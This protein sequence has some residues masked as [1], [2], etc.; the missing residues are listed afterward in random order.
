M[1]AAESD[2]GRREKIRVQGDPKR[3]LLRDLLELLGIGLAHH[4]EKTDD[5]QQIAGTLLRHTLGEKLLEQQSGQPRQGNFE[6]SEVE[7]GSRL[8]ER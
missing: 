2:A 7:D 8:K 5:H 3:T 4:N 6:A 1:K